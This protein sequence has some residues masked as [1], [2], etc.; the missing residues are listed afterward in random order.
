MISFLQVMNLFIQS[1]LVISN[2]VSSI[3]QVSNP[4]LTKS[5]IYY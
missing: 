5:F 2:H 4:I 3:T 1:Y